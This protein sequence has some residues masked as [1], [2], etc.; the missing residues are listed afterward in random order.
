MPETNPRG[1]DEC[2]RDPIFLLQKREILVLGLPADWSHDDDYSIRDGAGEV[3][4]RLDLRERF[5]TEYVVDIWHTESVWFTRQEAK[6]WA[7][8][9]HYRF[10]EGWRVYCVCCEGSLAGLLKAVDVEL[11]IVKEPR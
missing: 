4:S 7:E 11:R 5:G 10:S 3:V 9:H 2:T 8:A 1:R 6:A